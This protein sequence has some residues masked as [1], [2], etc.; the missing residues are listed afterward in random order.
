ML[1]VLIVELGFLVGV[2]FANG[3]SRVM[4]VDFLVGEGLT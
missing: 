4:R 3:L 1:E 2:G